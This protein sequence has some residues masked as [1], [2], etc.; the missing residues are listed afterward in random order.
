M[1]AL[2][3]KKIEDKSIVWFQ[4]SNSYLVV[5]NL[6]AEILKK[7]NQQ[8]DFSEIFIWLK[9]QIDAP[10]EFIK[11]FL[12]NTNILF[13]QNNRKRKKTRSTLHHL[14]NSNKYF[15][16]KYYCVYDY[17]FLIQFENEYLESLI[18]PS[19]SHLEVHK[20]PMFNF[21]YQVF[22]KDDAIVFQKNKTIIG[23]WNKN[24]FYVF[25]G[26]LSMQLLIDIYKKSEQHWMG[27]FHA[28]A[29]SNGKE[30]I[31]FLGDSGN[32]KSTSLALLNANE[33]DCIADDFVPIDNNKNIYTY[34]AAISIKKNSTK[35]LL[36]Y[37][38]ELK[39]S[40]EYHFKNSNKTVYFLPP[41][42]N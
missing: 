24:E 26:K 4:N 14:K 32:G 28:S 34:P 3:T 36:P 19:F 29:V 20:L 11:D 25:Q 16:Q 17:I 22:E 23:N 2:L 15:S 21:N 27:V 35:T 6:V 18:H 30:S 41:K 12:L 31:L 37:Y 13:L 9:T 38:P 1:S 5:E 8:V 33:F 7:L 42:K 10:E 40:T 39:N